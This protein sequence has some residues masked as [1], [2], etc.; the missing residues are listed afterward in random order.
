MISQKL[1]DAITL[2]L[3]E[4]DKGLDSLP[5]EIDPALMLEPIE[6]VRSLLATEKPVANNGWRGKPTLC[7]DFDGVCTT[8][9]SGWQGI[10]KITDPPVEGLFPFLAR[11]KPYFHITV[12]SSRSYWPE[13]RQ[14]MKMW[15]TEHYEEWI[16]TKFPT[17]ENYYDVLGILD[18]MEFPDHKPPAAVSLDDR[19][20]TFTGHWPSM[21]TL[22][23]FKPWTKGQD[24]LA[25]YN[26][27]LGVDNVQVE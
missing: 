5:V 13:G 23:N 2:L 6:T 27:L 17:G 14:A 26:N 8:Y 1:Y 20:L 7:L 3:D 16:A 10:D 9:S 12:F 19:T 22:L 4:I 15:F 11:A 25:D 24:N 21:V 18:I